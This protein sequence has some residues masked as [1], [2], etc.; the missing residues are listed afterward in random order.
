MDFNYFIFYEQQGKEEQEDEEGC[1]EPATEEVDK[2][3]KFSEGIFNSS[4]SPSPKNSNQ[5]KGG[6]FFRKCDS[7]F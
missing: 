5:I 7:F 4:F 2:G 6:F 3:G 1:D